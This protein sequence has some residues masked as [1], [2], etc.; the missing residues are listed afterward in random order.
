[1][2][3]MKLIP[4]QFKLFNQTIKV[5]LKN[6]LAYNNNNYGE[7]KYTSNKIRIQK[8]NEGVSLKKTMVE[9]TFYHELIHY[10]LN[11]MGEN[12]LGKNEKFVDIF[13]SL[14]HQYEKTKK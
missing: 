6:K 12:E 5:E 11:Y 2:K 3:T 13:A 14:L 1:M 7:A 9:Q 4:K 8:Q 10:I